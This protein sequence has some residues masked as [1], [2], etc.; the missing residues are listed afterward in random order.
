[1]EAN[2]QNILDTAEKQVEE[3][4]HALLKFEIFSMGGV[5]LAVATAKNYRYLRAK[6]HTIRKTIDCWIA[7]F[8]ILNQHR[9]LH[10]DHDFDPFEH[11][12]HLHIIHP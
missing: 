7:T 2:L 4:R 5:D 3:T 9:L 11:E 10:N 8:C 6:G 1:L 12:L